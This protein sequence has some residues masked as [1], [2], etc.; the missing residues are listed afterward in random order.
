M[1]T[2]KDTI[3]VVIMF[4]LIFAIAGIQLLSGALKQRCINIYTGAIL[5]DPNSLLS[6]FGVLCG[7]RACPA[8]PYFC[9]R[10]SF[11]LN[12]GITNYD[13]IFW[14]FNNMFQNITLESWSLT[15]HYYIIA[16]GYWVVFFF[17]PA[18]FIGAF[19]LLNLTLA[20][21]NY[22]FREKMEERQR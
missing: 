7:A 22:H 16:N 21:I 1:P 15:M 12:K 11:D 5:T 3:I 6:D 14:A 19:F 13:N 10:T 17:F 4:L 2:L 20:V 9:G 18:V 8:G